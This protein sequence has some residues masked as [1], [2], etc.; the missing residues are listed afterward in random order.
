MFFGLVISVYCE[1]L[2]KQVCRST[3]RGKMS[4]FFNVTTGL[5]K[6]KVVVL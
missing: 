5:L 4:E 3:L 2:M 1:N 6:V